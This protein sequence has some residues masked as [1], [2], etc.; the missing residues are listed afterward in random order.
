MKIRSICVYRGSSP[1]KNPAYSL[2]AASLA[3]ESC[4]PNIGLLNVEAYYNGLIDS[5]LTRRPEC[6]NG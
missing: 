1:G 5:M 6:A 2:A 4:K 3:R